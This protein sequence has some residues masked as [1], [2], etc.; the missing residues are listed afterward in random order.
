MCFL[1]PRLPEHLKWG[2]ACQS[3]ANLFS[4]HHSTLKVYLLASVYAPSHTPQFFQALTGEEKSF[5]EVNVNKR[6]HMLSRLCVACA[7][8]ERWSL[9]CGV[10][11]GRTPREVGQWGRG[12]P[13][14][15][16]SGQSSSGTNFRK[17]PANCFVWPL[18]TGNVVNVRACV[19]VSTGAGPLSVPGSCCL[20][21]TLLVFTAA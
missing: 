8:G 4:A 18:V 13:E 21:K 1:G 2:R 17:G 16:P 5:G 3:Q 20:R 15:G 9:P 11:E 19:R 14:R 12:W 10:R 7:E 6:P